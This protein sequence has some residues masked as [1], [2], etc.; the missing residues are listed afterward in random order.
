MQY[1]DSQIAS[2]LKNLMNQARSLFWSMAVDIADDESGED[3]DRIFNECVKR[4]PGAQ[5]AFEIWDKLFDSAEI[6]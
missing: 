1:A 3:I 5:E 4:V 2:G 6:N